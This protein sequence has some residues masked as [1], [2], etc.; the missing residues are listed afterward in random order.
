MDTII[1]GIDWKHYQ[2]F[3]EHIITVKEKSTKR[4]ILIPGIWAKIRTMIGCSNNE[5]KKRGPRITRINTNNKRR[6]GIYV[7]K[8]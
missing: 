4:A 2:Y 8:I 7:D 3:T 5:L 1:I 6:N